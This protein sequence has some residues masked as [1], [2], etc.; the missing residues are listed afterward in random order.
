M[1]FKKSNKSIKVIEDIKINIKSDNSKIEDLDID[2][3][4]IEIEELSD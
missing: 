4:E 3:D 2:N 1:N